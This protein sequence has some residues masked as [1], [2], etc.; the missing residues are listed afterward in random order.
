MPPE[1]ITS[2]Y[3]TAYPDHHGSPCLPALD[4]VRIRKWLGLDLVLFGTEFTRVPGTMGENRPQGWHVQLIL[5]APM[6][7]PLPD[8]R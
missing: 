2:A 7:R 6:K 3:L 8:R 1:R 4:R 5:A